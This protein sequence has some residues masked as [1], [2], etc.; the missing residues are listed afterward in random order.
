[1]IFDIH[2]DILGF[3]TSNIELF[4]LYPFVCSALK[5]LHHFVKNDLICN[6]FQRSGLESKCKTKGKTFT[7]Y[8]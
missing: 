3:V 6:L 2:V 5:F 4:F 7:S 1:M 8:H